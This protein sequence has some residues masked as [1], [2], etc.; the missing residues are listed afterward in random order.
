MERNKDVLG[1]SA[2][3][4]WGKRKL[5]ISL[6]RKSGGPWER[7]DESSPFDKKHWLVKAIETALWLQDSY[8]EQCGGAMAAVE[9]LLEGLAPAFLDSWRKN[10]TTRLPSYH[11]SGQWAGAL[12]AFW[13]HYSYGQSGAESHCLKPEGEEHPENRKLQ[14][15]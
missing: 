9:R 6:A 14:Q 4:Q 15:T 1:Q 11:I 8:K 13:D 2:W 3:L 7:Q 10:P 12:R 5:A